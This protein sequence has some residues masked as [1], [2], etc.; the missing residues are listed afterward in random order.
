MTKKK[1]V[2]KESDISENQVREYIEAHPEF[3]TNIQASERDLGEGVVDFQYHLL[4]NL[5]NRSKTLSQRYDL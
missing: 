5:Q 3:L 1:E 4:K 2:V